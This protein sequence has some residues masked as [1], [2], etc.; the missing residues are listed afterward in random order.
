[1][2]GSVAIELVAEVVIEVEC[3]DADVE[4]RE[5]EAQEEKQREIERYLTKRKHYGAT[6]L[7]I[8]YSVIYACFAFHFT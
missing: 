7:D 6:M 1:M 4:A 8:H 3:S 5:Y 2:G